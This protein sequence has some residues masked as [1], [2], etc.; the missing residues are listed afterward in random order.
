MSHV[1]LYFASS[2]KSDTATYQY[3]VASRS[4]PDVADDEINGRHAV[5]NMHEVVAVQQPKAE[6][7]ELIAQKFLP[8]HVNEL[9]EQS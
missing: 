9:A 8:S 1:T 2:I 4:A 6:A 3:S 5:G 7:V